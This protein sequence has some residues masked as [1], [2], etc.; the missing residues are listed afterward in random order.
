[1]G[2]AC[3]GLLG[4]VCFAASRGEVL[5]RC[6]R[7]LM[8]IAWEQRRHGVGVVRVAQHKA[9]VV[10]GGI[11]SGAPGEMAVS[12]EIRDGGSEREL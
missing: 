6:M 9:P 4:L 12:G 3:L 5:M 1:M 7:G 2:T 11:V 10:V 8:G